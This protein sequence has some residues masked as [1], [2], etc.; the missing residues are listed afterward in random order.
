MRRQGDPTNTGPSH[1][2]IRIT[3]Q[4]VPSERTRTS[5]R[6][7]LL[8]EGPPAVH[9]FLLLTLS[10][11]VILYEGEDRPDGGG[12]GLADKI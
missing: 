11:I 1:Q 4:R 3:G 10:G 12:V 2:K 7:F 5:W 6:K 9:S 8:C